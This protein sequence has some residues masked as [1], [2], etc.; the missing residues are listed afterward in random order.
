M[1]ET[2]KE[3]H[4]K[5]NE[6]AV[7]VHSNL[8]NNGLLGY[9]GVT[10]TPAIFDTL[11]NEPFIIPPNPGIVPNFP[12]DATGPQ[13]TNIRRVFK[14]DFTAFKRYMDVC[15]AISSLIIN[16]IDPVYLATLRLP[17]VGIGTRTPLEILAHL[18]TNYANITPSDLEQNGLAMQQPCDVNQPIEV[19]YKHIEDAMKFAAAGQTP[20][21]PE[22]ILS[23]AYQGI[24]RTSIFA[25]DC[26]IWKRQATAYK[27]W[28]QFKLDFR[29]AYKEYNEGL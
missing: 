3:L 23:I 10:V 19:F 11:S 14:E 9:L 7:K 27:T 4:L 22:Q 16:A 15:N 2:I 17:Y 5:L 28:E 18:Y 21:S 26:K 29:V 25:D 12:D 24:F 13:I 6:N 8:G 20:Y 1:Y